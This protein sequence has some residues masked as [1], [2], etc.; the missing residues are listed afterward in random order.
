LFVVHVIVAPVVVMP[1]TAGLVI[2]RGA[3]TVTV[4]VACD[5]AEPA[6]FV[7]VRV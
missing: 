4:T 6:E 7:A 2:A 3:G 5:V 1:P